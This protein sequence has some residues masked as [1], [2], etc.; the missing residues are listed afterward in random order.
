[1]KLYN[2]SVEQNG[3]FDGKEKMNKRQ[4]NEAS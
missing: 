2:F 1:M 4:N 3:H